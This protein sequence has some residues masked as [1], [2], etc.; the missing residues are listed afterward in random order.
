ML[1]RCVDFLLC[2]AGT[3][4]EDFARELCGYAVEQ[5]KEFQG[6]LK[7]D[8]DLIKLSLALPVISTFAWRSNGAAWEG[9]AAEQ[10]S[11]AQAAVWSSAARRYSPRIPRQV[12]QLAKAGRAGFAAMAMG[13][14][15][16]VLAGQL[17]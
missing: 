11:S 4:P 17:E 5:R 2:P 3:S 6:K 7:Q 10:R 15:A 8:G 16:V 9:S 14:L 13:S 12:R 1:M